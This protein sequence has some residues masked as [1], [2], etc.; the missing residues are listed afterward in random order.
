MLSAVSLFSG[1]GGFD[2]G[3]YQAGVEIIWANDIDK[4]A[5]AAYRS[6]L[7][8]VTF[9]EKDIRDIQLFPEADVLIGCYP[10]TGFSLAA[11]RRWKDRKV[12][13][14]SE[15]DDNFLYREFVRALTQVKPKFIFI[16]NVGGMI[17][18]QDGWFF[19]QQLEGFRKQ[20]YCVSHKIL[21]AQDFGVPQSRRRMF[22]V[23]VHEAISGFNYSFPQPTHGPATS[24]PY[25]VLHD[26]IGNMEF[27]PEGEYFSIP[28]HGHYLTRNR[29][30]AW[31]E[32][33]Y[34]I[35]ANAHHIPLH[36]MGEP[37]VYV[38]KDKWALQG[39][40]NRRLSWRECK[41]IQGL[42][43]ALQPSGNLVDKYRIVGNA[44]PPALGSAIVEPVVKFFNSSRVRLSLIPKLPSQGDLLTC[45]Q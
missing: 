26:T 37:M 13:D 19:E 27:W 20:G 16:E 40:A 36:P 41:K 45:I 18:A 1:C 38:S 6:I 9:H 24:K 23:G 2:Y 35:V 31:D 22:I 21:Y 11:R 7:P 4:H 29:K 10:C 8:N 44:V 17:S 15:N 5:S 42:P 43:D 28:F 12:R 14:L 30:R 25:Q 3:A 34:T 39:N 32:L 33:S